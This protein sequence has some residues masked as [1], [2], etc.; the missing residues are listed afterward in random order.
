M[1]ESS[2]ISGKKCGYPGSVPGL[3]LPMPAAIMSLKTALPALSLPIC[4]K[5]ILNNPFNCHNDIFPVCLAIFL[6]VF[7][8]SYDLM[9]MAYVLLL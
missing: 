1:Q 5:D 8:A 3:L 4:H 6:T 7:T 2:V 9:N